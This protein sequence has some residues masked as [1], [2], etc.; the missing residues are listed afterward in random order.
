MPTVRKS[1]NPGTSRTRGPAGAPPPSK[2]VYPPR[3]DT[4]LLLPYAEVAAGRSFLEIGTGSGLVALT[5]ARRGARVVATDRNPHALARLAAIA[6][7]EDLDL[8][9]V[10]TDLAR[11]LGRFD[12]VVANPPYLPTRPEERDLDRWHNLAVDGGP[13][14]CATTARLVAALP[15]LLRPGGSAFILTSTVQSPERLREIWEAWTAKGGSVEPVAHRDLEG[16]RLEVVRLRGPGRRP[17][18]SS[19][20]RTKAPRLGTRDRPRTPRAHRSG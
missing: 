3:A 19:A 17:S 1:V 12:R 18:R 14:G 11:G 13:D 10:R 8:H 5:A 20:P 16:E 7:S 6:R 4:F 15:D 9:V 2:E